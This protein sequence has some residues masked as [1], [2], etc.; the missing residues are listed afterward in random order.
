MARVKAVVLC[1]GLDNALP[2]SQN[3][4]KGPRPAIANQ[5]PDGFVGRMKMKR[6]TKPLQIPQRFP[7]HSDGRL[8]ATH[9]GCTCACII[10][11]CGLVKDDP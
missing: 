6:S 2:A 4:T 3:S 8:G 5:L 10:R 9:V 11:F 1:E 7:R